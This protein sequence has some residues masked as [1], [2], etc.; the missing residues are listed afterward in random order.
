MYP[1]ELLSCLWE[2]KHPR[3][4]SIGVLATRFGEDSRKA[5]GL[6]SAGTVWTTECRAVQAED[7]HFYDKGRRLSGELS[8]GESWERERDA[9]YTV[10]KGCLPYATIDEAVFNQKVRRFTGETARGWR[11]LFSTMTS[12]GYFRPSP[13]LTWMIGEDSW[14]LTPKEFRV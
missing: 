11:S 14:L 12:G 13:R 3:L 4:A 9:T 1:S 10:P 8:H 5:V 6:M 7:D 2:F